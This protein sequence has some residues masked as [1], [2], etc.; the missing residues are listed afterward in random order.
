M[1]SAPTV[2]RRF[3][4]GR[5]ARLRHFHYN[6]SDL[7][8]TW[9]PQRVRSSRAVDDHMSW[10]NSRFF[11]INRHYAFSGDNNIEF[12]VGQ[13]MGMQADVRSRRHNHHVHMV[14]TQV[15]ASQHSTGK[16]RPVPTM[17][18]L[19]IKNNILKAKVSSG[20]QEPLV[21]PFDIRI[22]P[23][24]RPSCAHRST[25]HLRYVAFSS[26]APVTAI[27]FDLGG[28]HLRAAVEFKCSQV[29]AR[30]LADRWRCRIPNSVTG[31]GVSGN[32][33]E[34]PGRSG[35]RL[36][37]EGWR[38]I[39]PGVPIIFGFPGPIGPGG[40]ILAAPTIVGKATLVPDFRGMIVKRTG[41]PVH[42][43]NDM[44]AA[45]GG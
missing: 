41:R 4:T 45:R 9:V 22:P 17:C 18:D 15:G 6:N 33:L 16:Y 27:L 23:V 43:L 31:G 29:T 7:F 24:G 12:L 10:P 13:G 1:R 32:Y 5:A 28:T 42:M 19:L 26:E 20:M 34:R 11:A 35:I 36:R 37:R 8:R 14:R 25:R 3:H 2:S 38:I 30:S 40:S 44:S 39:S 21:S